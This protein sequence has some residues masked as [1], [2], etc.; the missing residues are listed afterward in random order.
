MPNVKKVYDTYKDSGFDVIGVSLDFEETTLRGYI[1]EN[2]IPWRQIFDMA[3]GAGSLAKQYGIRGIPAP[4]L[5]DKEGKLIS[6]NARGHHL[7]KFVA[8]AVKDTP[9]NE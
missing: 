8:E 9:T 3:S 1:K 6:Y 2:D 5:I 7:E 4:W